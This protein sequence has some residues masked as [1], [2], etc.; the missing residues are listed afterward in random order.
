MTTAAAEPATQEDEPT[1]ITETTSTSIVPQS[2][3]I[4][5]PPL[6][7]QMEL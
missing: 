4:G 1:P 7:R 6:R 2:G 3:W 5:I